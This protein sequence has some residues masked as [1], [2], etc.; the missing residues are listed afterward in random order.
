MAVMPAAMRMANHERDKVIAVMPEI[1]LA[2][3]EE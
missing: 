1:T 2:N 3:V